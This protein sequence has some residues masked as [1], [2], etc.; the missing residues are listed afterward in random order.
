V[1]LARRLKETGHEAIAVGWANAG[2]ELTDLLYKWAD[3]VVVVKSLFVECVPAA[4]LNKVVVAEIGRDV[5]DDAK[6]PVLQ[7]RLDEVLPGLLRLL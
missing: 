6:H 4:Y 1:A 2:P 5:W 3:K 7:A